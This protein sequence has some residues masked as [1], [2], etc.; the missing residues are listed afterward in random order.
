MSIVSGA[1]SRRLRSW[2]SRSSFAQSS[3]TSTRSAASAG[4]SRRSSSKGMNEYSSGSGASPYRYIA[5]S[6]PSE[7]SASFVARIEPRASPSG[8]SCVTRRKRSW[9]RSAS[10]TA[11][12]SLVFLLWG[13]LIDELRHADPTLDRR[14]V[15]ERQLGSPLHSQLAGQAGLEQPMCRREP[16][17]RLLALRL[18][19]EHAHEHPR[20][21]QI[22]GGLDAGHGDEAD[23]RVLQLPYALRD[24][25]AHGLVDAA[26]PFVHEPTSSPVAHRLVSSDGRTGKAC[27][28]S[29]R[30]RKR[31]LTGPPARRPRARLRPARTPD[32]RDSAR[33]RRAA[34][35]VPGGP[36]RHTRA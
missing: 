15:F 8:F 20:M 17:Q 33:R 14:I 28:S 9:E 34:L 18:G 1:C 23:P 3:A 26:H 21:A 4:G 13:E 12:K 16:G 30:H 10:A 11:C 29:G 6:L 24:D 25:L 36:A 22:R 19:A 32:S 5:V 7:S 27:P 2:P 35:R 31:R